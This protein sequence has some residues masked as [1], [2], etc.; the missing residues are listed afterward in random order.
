M[1]KKVLVI[2]DDRNLCRLLEIYLKKAGFQVLLAYDGFA[3]LEL[4]RS[5]D[6]DLVILDIM[7]P[8]MD[9]W[10]VCQEIRN[11]SDMPIIML[12]ARGEKYDRITG[13]DLGAD[14]YLTKPF[15]PDEV[16]AQVR[17]FFRRWE[18]NEGEEQEQVLKFPGLE[19]N[20][21]RF[22]VRVD[23]ETINLAPREFDLLW[24]LAQNRGQVFSREQLLDKI[25]GYDFYGDIRTVDTHIKRLRDKLQS[26]R[27]PVY[28]HTV[29]GVGY[30]FEVVEDE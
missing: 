19:I 1:N 13:L 28:L 5:E 25:W 23:G 27:G 24:F 12:T 16:V 21:S 22:K 2:D 8:G 11:F 14:I 18:D 30:K 26:D 9:G 4:A 15:D 3:G 6:P 10:E 7:L 20:K 29:W 17:A